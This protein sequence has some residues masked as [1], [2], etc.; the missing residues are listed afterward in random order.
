MTATTV[1]PSRDIERNMVV[2]FRADVES[3]PD[4]GSSKKRASGA[5]FVFKYTVRGAFVSC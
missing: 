5:K 4:V 3:R 2:T 1:I